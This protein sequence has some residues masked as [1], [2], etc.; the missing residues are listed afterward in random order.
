MS[1]RF[2]L[3]PLHRPGGPKKRERYTFDFVANELSLFR[4]T[5]ASKSDM[6]GALSD[7]KF[8]PEMAR[9]FNGTTVAALIPEAPISDHRRVALFVCSECGDLGCGAITALVSR[10]GL[11]AQWSD[12]AYEN[13]YEPMSR[14]EGLGPFTFEWAEYVGKILQTIVGDYP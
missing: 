3:T 5:I 13:G 12:F 6:S 11:D 9:R 14:I 4:T 7:P 8:E 2:Q 10:A 1:D